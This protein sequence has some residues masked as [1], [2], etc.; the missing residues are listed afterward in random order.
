MSPLVDT[1]ACLDLDRTVIYSAAAL[2]LRMPDHEAPRLLCVEVY[3]GAP[4]SFMTEPGAA[5]LDELAA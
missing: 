1:V 5:S 3:K 4:L 2:N